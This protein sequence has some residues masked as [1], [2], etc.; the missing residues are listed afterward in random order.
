MTEVESCNMRAQVAHAAVALLD[1]TMAAGSDSFAGFEA[2]FVAA[3]LRIAA[4][5]ASDSG[6]NA[7]VSAETFASG[8]GLTRG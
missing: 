7:A 3:C 8:V 4:V 2:G 5:A 1:N 6:C